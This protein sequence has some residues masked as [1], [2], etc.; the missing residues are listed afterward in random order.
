MHLLCFLFSV[1]FLFYVTMTLEL[2]SFL[3]KRVSTQALLPKIQ[4]LTFG[5]HT[6][7]RNAPTAFLV[8]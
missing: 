1:A 7:L 6:V 4:A 8:V 3:N 5:T 2:T